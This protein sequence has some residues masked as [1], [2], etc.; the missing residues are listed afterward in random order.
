MADKPIA[1]GE[2]D[3]LRRIVRGD[4]KAL[5]AEMGQR[6]RELLAEVEQRVAHRF[7]PSEEAG[8]KLGRRIAEIITDANEAI[9]IAVG[10]AEKEADGYKAEYAPLGYPR[11]YWKPEKREEMRRALIADLDARIGNAKL[12]LQRQ[13]I[14]LLKRLS[15]EALESTSA[16]AFLTEIPTVAEL[17]PSSRLAE[18]EAQFSEP[19][20]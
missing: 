12:R 17:V 18:L 3:E 16:R 14:D 20:S 4:I 13:E 15:M 7:E 10:E 5:I 9:G 1:K 19:G 2:R 11:I 6:Q 8:R